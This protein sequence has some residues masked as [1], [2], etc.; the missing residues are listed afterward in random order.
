MREFPADGLLI[1]RTLREPRSWEIPTNSPP[2]VAFGRHL[3]G[4][5]YAGI[6]NRK[7][8]QL[9]V[10][11]LAGLGHRRIAFIGGDPQRSTGRERLEGFRR[12]H[13]RL[14][15]A[16][17]PACISPTE[18]N[19][20]GGHEG[21]LKALEGCSPPTAALCFNDVVA[22]GAMEALKELGRKPGL[23]FG[24]V[25]FNN[26][27]DAASSRPGLTTID[28]GPVRLGKVAAELLIQRINEPTAPIRKV[29]LQPRLV[30]RE[31]CGAK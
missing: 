28:T 15:L 12:A 27:T 25:G 23:D 22:L 11:H 20:A 31:S 6:N 7:G 3:P 9:A 29:I 4:A 13:Q 5:D 2:I 17:D 14:G 8:A 16:P 19:R 1:C 24:I 10:T 21:L 30:I 18:P 26:V